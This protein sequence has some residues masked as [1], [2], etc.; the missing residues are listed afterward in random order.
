VLESERETLTDVVHAIQDMF[1]SGELFGDSRHVR[2]VE[3]G[4][5]A[6]Q[7][8]IVFDSPAAQGA[9]FAYIEAIEGLVSEFPG[10]PQAIAA[11]VIVHLEE[12]VIGNGWWDN[13]SIVPLGEYRLVWPGWQEQRED[14]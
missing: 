14:A 4:L 2:F 1:T 13:A 10:D 6:G 11:L 12:V 5:T 7:L 3:V 9:R 8:T